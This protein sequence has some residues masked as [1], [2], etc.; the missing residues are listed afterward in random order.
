MTWHVEP[1]VW[2][3]Y[4]AGQLDLAAEASVETHVVGCAECRAAANS[5]VAP[6]A[7]EAV[8]TQVRAAGSVAVDDLVTIGS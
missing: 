1:S 7:A 6:E 2:E 8:W 5:H 4:V 3:A